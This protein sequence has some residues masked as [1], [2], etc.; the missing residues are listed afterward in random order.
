[1]NKDELM[2]TQELREAVATLQAT[3]F[4]MCNAKDADEV[5]TN[6]IKAKELLINIYKHNVSRLSE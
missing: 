3:V 2:S 5:C 4:S 6:F 1:M